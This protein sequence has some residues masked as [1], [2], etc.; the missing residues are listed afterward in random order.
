[1][2]CGAVTPHEPESVVELSVLEVPGSVPP[3]ASDRPL[4]VDCDVLESDAV[5]SRAK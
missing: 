5:A 1:L 3:P 4:D 2:L